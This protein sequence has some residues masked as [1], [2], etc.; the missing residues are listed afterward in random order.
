MNTNECIYAASRRI[1]EV[2]DRV[3]IKPRVFNTET[4]EEVV[5]GFPIEGGPSVALKFVS[6]SQDF[7]VHCR[8]DGLVRK[9]P[10]EKRL[11]ILEACNM[12]NEDYRFLKFGLD[13][14]GDVYVSY[15]F[16]KASYTC[17]GEMAFE[18]V[19]RTFSILD[20]AYPVL[21]RALYVNDNNDQP[22]KTNTEQEEAP[23]SSRSMHSDFSYEIEELLDQT[24]GDMRPDFGD[25]SCNEDKSE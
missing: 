19:R 1:V 20:D 23:H 10:E 24:R 25:S 13:S 18:L 21:M 16:L 2:L 8:L 9:I 7:D 17:T 15:D 12:L 22:A 4:V 6:F 3:G 14:D 5:V 11:P